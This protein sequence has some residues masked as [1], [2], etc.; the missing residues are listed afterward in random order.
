MDFTNIF[1]KVQKFR[2]NQFFVSAFKVGSGQFIAQA[3]S[4][5]SVP[6]LSRIYSDLSYGNTALITSTASIL[7]N[8][9]ALGLTSAIMKPEDD[10]EAKIVFTT[11]VTVNFTIVTGFV[12]ICALL[13]HK[14]KLFSVSG[15]YGLALAMMWMYAILY[16]LSLL[17]EVY[18]NRQ[19][20]YN[21]LFVNP[22]I[23]SITN[24]VV[25]IPLGLLGFGYEGFMITY[26]IQYMCICVH[27][28]WG[29]NPFASHYRF[30]DF[31]YVM[32]TYKEYILFQYPS[33]FIANFGTEYPTQYLGRIFTTQ[34]L[35]GYSLCVR[36]M[37]YPIR[38]IATPISTVYFRTATEYQRKGKNLSDFT[39]KMIRGILLVSAVP[40]ALF[41]LTSEWLFAV[42]FGQAWREA[43]TLAGFLIIQYVLLFCAQTVSYCRVSIG[44]QQVNLG[45]SVVQLMVAAGSCM[46]GYALF[47]NMESTVLCFSLGQCVYNICDMAINFS[48][49]SRNKKYLWKYLAISV[50]YVLVLLFLWIAKEYIIC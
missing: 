7:I 12:L 26:I 24:F 20:R 23:G 9:A 22:I 27:M 44:K 15:S 37:K 18:V 31:R 16:S 11:A 36:V 21:R 2:Q 13:G 3:M 50:P 49:M 47:G 4:L 1:R 29:N 30:R 17:M 33:N 6:I 8:A 38:L 19:G 10:D 46:A 14:T 40:V 39:Y 42:I 32:R 43:G 25:A 45:I 41:I 48:C 35:G 28:M 34:Q 5:L